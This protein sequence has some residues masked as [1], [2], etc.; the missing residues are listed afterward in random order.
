M[1]VWQRR[2]RVT[3]GTEPPAVNAVGAPQVVPDVREADRRESRAIAAGEDGL[4]VVQHARVHELLSG[5]IGFPV[6]AEPVRHQAG[7]ATIRRLFAGFVV[8]KRNH[9]CVADRQFG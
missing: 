8:R 4:V 2:V 3:G 5:W 7:S 6:L 9:P 1:F